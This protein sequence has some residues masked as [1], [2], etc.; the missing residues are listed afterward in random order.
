ME[1]CKALRPLGPAH[2]FPLYCLFL[3]AQ[4]KNENILNHKPCEI[5]NLCAKLCLEMHARTAFIGTYRALD[6]NRSRI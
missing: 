3:L 6:T 1:E 2:V 4:G 5:G